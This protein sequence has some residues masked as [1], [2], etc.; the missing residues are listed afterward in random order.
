MLTFSLL[1]SKSIFAEQNDDLIIDLDKKVVIHE[2]GIMFINENYVLES[3]S[4]QIVQDRVFTI[5]FDNSFSVENIKF[6]I[7]KDAEWIE[8]NFN[9]IDLFESSFNEY[10]LLIPSILPVD[11]GGTL[12][13]RSSYLLSKN[14]NRVNKEYRAVIPVYPIL[15]NNI[16]SFKM[17]VAFSHVAEITNV[18]TPLDFSINPKDGPSTIEL[19][20]NFVEPLKFENVIVKYVSSSTEDYLVYCETFN[21][22]MII[23][24]NR[25]SMEDSFFILNKGDRISSFGL[26]LPN[27]ASNIKAH[28]SIGPIHIETQELDQEEGLISVLVFPRSALKPDEKL[29]FTLKYSLPKKNLITA[30]EGHQLLTYQLYDF[31]YYIQKNSM[32]VVFPGGAR[33]ENSQP[34]FSTIREN[35]LEREVVYNLGSILPDEH[36]IFMITYT[37]SIF[38]ASFRYILP[39]IILCGS[40]GLAYFYSRRRKVIGEK[41]PEQ[42]KEKLDEFLEKYSKRSSLLIDHVE[43]EQ[44]FETKAISRDVFEKN[45]ADIK[46]K[47]NESR[48]TLNRLGKIVEKERPELR[49]QINRLGKSEIELDEVEKD[50]KNLGTRLRQRR[51]SRN[52]YNARRRRYITTRRKTINTIRRTVGDIKNLDK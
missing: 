1:N 45:S 26:L 40:V 9:K 27:S 29:S 21:Q 25:I 37:S 52:D 11:L 33:I 28:D 17:E 38:G 6:E 36:R 4:E 7:L 41:P 39:L 35:G 20:S 23:R 43:L 19:T 16:S 34:D 47:L 32:F 15:R 3:I 8:L 49:T 42:K 44:K 5:G 50:I 12:N 46:R 24:S 22:R 31:P 51:I 48:N 10:E 30:S 14:L 2:T 18:S 13:L